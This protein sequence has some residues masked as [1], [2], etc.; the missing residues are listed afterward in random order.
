MPT[1]PARMHKVI[2]AEIPKRIPLGIS[3]GIFKGIPEEI[4]G[5]NPEVIAGRIPQGILE[6]SYRY[7]RNSS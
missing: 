1:A 7:T 3:D 5:W 2:T 6:K 4:P